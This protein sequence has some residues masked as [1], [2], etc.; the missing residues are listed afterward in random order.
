MRRCATLLAGG[1]RSALFCAA[2]LLV[3]GWGTIATVPTACAGDGSY[4][5]ADPRRSSSY[6]DYR[7]G[8]LTNH[9]VYGED[10]AILAGDGLFTPLSLLLHLGM[11]QQSDFCR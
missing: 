3:N 6:D 8:K 7:R 2:L 10:I 1:K 5:V 9:K 4:Y 11:Y